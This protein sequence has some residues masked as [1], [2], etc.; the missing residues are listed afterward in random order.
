MMKFCGPE[1]WDYPVYYRQFNEVGVK[2]LMI[3]IDQEANS[4][5][6]I[7]TRVQSLV[8]NFD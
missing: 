4:F 8:E 1:E 6:Q 2:S 3:E 7:R 5:E